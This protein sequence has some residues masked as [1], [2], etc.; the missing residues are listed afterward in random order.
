[1]YSAILVL[2]LALIMSWEPQRWASSLSARSSSPIVVSPSQYFDGNDGP[3]S[4]FFLRVG[5]PEQYVRVLV[6]TASPE[7]MV[8]LSEYGCSDSVFANAPSNCASS[9]GDLFTSNKSSSWNEL[10]I[11]NI[12]NNGVGLEANLGYSQRSEFATD[13]IGLSLNGPKL[14]NQ[15][16]AGI[17]TPEPFYLGILGLNPQQVNLS[18]L[19]NSSSP[20]FFTTLKD[21]S[22]IP[23]LSW[24]YTAGAKYRLKQVYGQLIFSGYDQSRFTSNS[25][26]FTMADD[27]TRDLV[28]YLQ[29]ISYSGST[30]S[31]LLSNPIDIFIDSTDPN[32]W[33][34]DSVCNEF[35]KAFGLT[36]D[37][38]S[39]L[40]LVNDTQNT[41][42]LNS[43]AEVTFR[44]SDVGTGGDAV[45]ITL[46]YEAFALTAK[47][48]LVD[49]SSYY[50]P[51][52]RAA[53]STQYTLG[54]VFLQE[55]YLSTDYERGVFNVS[56]CSWEEDS[57]EDIVEIM[58]KDAGSSEC[59]G[60]GCSSGGSSSGS[61]SSLSR[62]KVAG[63]AVGAVVGFFLLLGI[64]LFYIRR[65]RQKSRNKAIDP[66]PN[67]SV[68]TGP[69]HNGGPPESSLHDEHD[70]LPQSAFW[71]PDTLNDSS[72]LTASRN[73]GSSGGSGCHENSSG[74][75][76]LDG[77][78]TQI[79]PVYHEL[80]G[81]KV[82]NVY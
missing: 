18:T 9:R 17:A 61:S 12:N 11:F 79:K 56:A 69:V 50:F 59:S 52:K 66:R 30:S 81:S 38:D 78:N 74:E 28:V 24:S 70:S 64:L 63:I 6:S 27:I 73:N 65:H 39:G 25:V 47:P 13:D 29:S 40:Y 44:L 7:S 72:G 71:S 53:N 42:L 68:L 21:Q 82:P 57:Q 60:S 22:M 75:N 31:I 80:P 8:V 43:E 34:P 15:T 3:W 77:H 58:S 14:E 19:G 48:P 23:S 35:E 33:L 32:L 46:P 62:G 49:N 54:R 16:L 55:A 67:V 76:E 20:S 36:M 26:S 41:E 1:M 2:L 51:L 45:V 4:S 5:T 37:N 10:G